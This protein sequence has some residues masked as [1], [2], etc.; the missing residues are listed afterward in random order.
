MHMQKVVLTEALGPRIT[1]YGEHPCP[2]AVQTPSP[3]PFIAFST[4]SQTPF[5]LAISPA[6]GEVFQAIC[7]CKHQ[8]SK[9]ICLGTLSCVLQGGARSLFDLA[10]LG[11]CIMAMLGRI[12]PCK[13]H[14]ASSAPTKKTEKKRNGGTW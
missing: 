4:G 13:P 12:C 1:I 11:L 3:I 7:S 6:V 10:C 5:P 14:R 2:S 9:Q 8:C